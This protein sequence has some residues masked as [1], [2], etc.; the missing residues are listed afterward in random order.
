[1]TIKQR[2]SIKQIPRP[3][4]Y[5]IYATDLSA[6]EGMLKVTDISMHLADGSAKEGKSYM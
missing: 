5:S 6:L 3:T 4:D 2:Q 1:M